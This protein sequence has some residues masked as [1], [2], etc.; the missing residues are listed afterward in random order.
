MDFRSPSGTS[1]PFRNSQLEDFRPPKPSLGL[2]SSKPIKN[3]AVWGAIGGMLAT[4][5]VQRRTEAGGS[6]LI[7]LASS[8][9]LVA[10]SAASGK[11][12]GSNPYNETIAGTEQE[13][14][15]S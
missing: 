3:G 14:S 7:S 11:V 8:S 15:R 13:D 1:I 2:P 4:E 12:K 10:L 9:S 5:V 6:F